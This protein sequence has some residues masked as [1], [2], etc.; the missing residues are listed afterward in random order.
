MAPVF[1]SSL[2][3]AWVAIPLLLAGCG[4]DSEEVSATSLL[5][6][7]QPVQ[8]VAY[9]SGPIPFEVVYAPLEIFAPTLEVLLNGELQP[10]PFV[11]TSSELLIT[12]VVE[13]PGPHT[14]EVSVFGREDEDAEF[15]EQ[16][17]TLGFTVVPAEPSPTLPLV[18]TEYGE[19]TIAQFGVVL[20]TLQDVDDDGIRDFLTGS[21]RSSAGG[22]FSGLVELRSGASGSLLRSWT[23]PDFSEFGASLSFLDDLDD[24]GLW[25][26]VVGAPSDSSAFLEGGSVTAYSSATGQELWRFEGES[27]LERAGFD[28]ATIED[29]DGDGLREVLV[30]SAFSH[31][32][33]GF[34]SGS[35][36]ILSGSDGSVLLYRDGPDPGVQFGVSVGGLDDIDGDGTADLAVGAW[37]DTDAG[38]SAG[39]VYGVSG[40][41]GELLWKAIGKLTDDHLGRDLDTI[42]DF[43]GDGFRDLL[44]GVPEAVREPFTSIGEVRVVSGS[45]GSELLTISGT[46]NKERLGQQLARIDD[47]N[48]DGVGEWALAAPYRFNYIGRVL[49]HDGATGEL[50][51]EVLGPPNPGL[52]GTGLASL[53]DLDGNG[54]PELLVGA[55]FDSS[56]ELAFAGSVRVFGG[57]SEVLLTKSTLARGDSG[58]VSLRVQGSVP[59]GLIGAPFALEAGQGLSRFVLAT[60]SIPESGWMVWEL[61][62]AAIDGTTELSLSVRGEDGSLLRSASVNLSAGYSGRV[63]ADR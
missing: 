14:I 57:A 26:F 39:A 8:T 24:D 28:L 16:K 54:V 6:F 49:V 61:P 44:V 48:G 1:R 33:V 47:W 15:E 29:R 51:H 5:S 42:E 46:Q 21:P 55:P 36:R 13:E 30:G 9:E 31:T 20:E 22:S 56:S 23:G 59:P 60:G 40:S 19:A 25:D 45:D 27:D 3:T 4:S 58:V 35:I 50:L 17:V 41:T 34:N 11:V 18:Y 62:L 12:V 7:V 43:D 32:P 53:D 37:G 38:P 2:S 10:G 52:F 63:S